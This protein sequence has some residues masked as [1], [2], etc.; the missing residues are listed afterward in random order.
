MGE[1]YYPEIIDD[2]DLEGLELVVDQRVPD[3]VDEEDLEGLGEL[4]RGIF[5]RLWPV[6]KR[7]FI[8]KLR[9]VI[10]EIAPAIVERGM[11]KVLTHGGKPIFVY[12][13]SKVTGSDKR[14]FTQAGIA[15]D[16]KY[17]MDTPGKIST[18]KNTIITG[19]SVWFDPAV[20]SLSDLDTIKSMLAGTF[21]L[22]VSDKDMFKVPINFV[23]DVNPE[24]ALAID[25]NSAATQVDKVVL[26]NTRVERGVFRLHPIYVKKNVSV[27][28]KAE[29]DSTFTNSS[30]YLYVALIGKEL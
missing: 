1:L 29:W 15:T 9:P 26:R 24:I 10:K 19:L 3:D 6:Y 11:E 21:T 25:G 8:R 20:L 17:N 27:E 12:H 4:E 30:I 28:L 7:R 14:F 22:K 2:Q 16:D 23:A 13:G 5:R 18:E